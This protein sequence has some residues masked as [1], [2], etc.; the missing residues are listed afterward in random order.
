[1]SYPQ[2]QT[3]STPTGGEPP[4]WAPFYGAG[5]IQAVKR[6]FRKYATFSGRASRSEY[7]WWILAQFVITIAFL[8][9]YLVLGFVGS[10]IEDGR[11]VPGPGLFA[12]AALMLLWLLAIIVPGIALV[13]RRLHDVNLSGWLALVLLVPG[14]GGLLVLIFSLLPPS[15][16]GQ[17]FD[18]PAVA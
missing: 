8:A 11:T 5:P 3:Y 14:V 9:L 18:R 15:P 16:D 7:W 13:V 2:E 6:F 10:T 12:G 4:L 1:M 17:R